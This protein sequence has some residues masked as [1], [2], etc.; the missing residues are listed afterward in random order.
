MDLPV[1][2]DHIAPLAFGGTLP[3]AASFA[4]AKAVILPIPLEST[5]SYVNG[6][7]NGPREILVAS[8][9]ME[10]W[11]EELN[12]DI[13]GIG[14]YTLPEMELPFDDMGVLMA[15]IRRVVAALVEHD[16]FPVV[17]GGEH[18]ITSP[19]VAAMAAKHPG[20][21]V[22]QIDAHA[23]L[24]ECYMGTRYN[25]A[26]AMRRVLEFARCTQVGIRSLSTEEAKA[27]PTLPTDIFFD[28]DMRQ[29]KNWIEQVVESLGETV[30][31]TID[32]DGMDPA[33]MPAVGTPEPGGLSWY[34]MLSLLRSVIS[35]RHVVGCDLVELCPIPGMVAPNFLCAKLIYK[36]LTYRFSK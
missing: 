28:V 15:E 24:R 2:Y 25:H 5:T 35:N 32:C 20:L 13:H 30:Y 19:V 27:A 29:D 34:E 26:C 12:T 36:I 10:L 11:D 31:I 4:N 7:R 14:I 18:S 9:H 23:D 33:I 16:K 6:T 3:E 1:K 21:S 17:L 8:S 22:L